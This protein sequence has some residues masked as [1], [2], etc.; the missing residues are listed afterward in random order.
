MLSSVA[1]GRGPNR[2]WPGSVFPAEVIVV[3]VRW[4]LRYGL[5]HRDVEEL[6]AERATEVDH[7]TISRWVQRFTPLLADAARFARHSPGCLGHGPSSTLTVGRLAADR[8]D[9]REHRRDVPL[10]AVF[11]GIDVGARHDKPGRRLQDPAPANQ[12]LAGR[13]GEQMQL[14]LRGYD[15][16]DDRGGRP[17][18]GVVGH[19]A[20]DRAVR[21]SVVLCEVGTDRNLQLGEALRAREDFAVEEGVERRLLDDLPHDLQVGYRAVVNRLHRVLHSDSDSSRLTA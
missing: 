2:V 10:G 20:D 6:L 18:A 7:V 14:V 21:E 8:H 16:A 17:G 4:Y 19:A 11:H 15:I 5:S 1:P 12:L 3:A 13:G 9:R